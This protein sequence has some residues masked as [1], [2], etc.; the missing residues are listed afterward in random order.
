MIVA[1]EEGLSGQ[2]RRERETE[3]SASESRWRESAF[4]ELFLG[5]YTRIVAVL[6]RLLGDRTQAEEL[7]TDVFW[8]LY[9]QPL[10]RHTNDNPVGWL[11]RTATNLGIDAL[12]AAARRKQYEQAA[13][14]ARLDA[15]AGVDPL[16]EILGAEKRDRVRAVLASIKPARAQILILRASGLS[17]KELA[18][19]LGVKLG[20][21]GTMLNRAEAE[22]RKR[23]LKLHG[24]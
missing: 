10:S 11:Y 20:G 21:V 3:G 12:R 16:D 14:R 23:Y 7:A 18:D 24:L 1:A 13:G 6:C 9:R 4:E 15:S 2:V 22:F 5:N 8:K 17:Y 19:S